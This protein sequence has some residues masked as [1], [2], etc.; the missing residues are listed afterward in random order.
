VKRLRQIVTKA[1]IAKGKKRTES[2]E[3]LRPPN[4]PTSILGCWVINHHYSAKKVGKYVEVSGKFDVNVWYAYN[5]H[6]KTAVYTETI[7]Y[8]DRIKLH[9]RDEEIINDSNEVHVKVLQQPNCIEA[10]INQRGDCFNI[11]IEREFLVEVIG[12]TKVVVSVHPIEFEEEWNF[13]DDDDED[14]SSSSSS[15]SSLSE[16]FDYKNKKSADDSSSFQ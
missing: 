5:N 10:I 6:S 8:K 3:M 11:V 1:V 4:T 7:P 15:S 14:E 13:D 16:E 9:Y 12:E 2:S